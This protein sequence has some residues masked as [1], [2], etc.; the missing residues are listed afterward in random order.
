[1]PPNFP[2]FEKYCKPQ[3]DQIQRKPYQDT[4]HLKTH[5]HKKETLK[6]S[7]VWGPTSRL[8]ADLNRSH[9]RRLCNNHIFYSGGE[10]MDCQSTILNPAKKKN[11]SNKNKE[12]ANGY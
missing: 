9:G 8:T 7:G 2:I 11:S 10:R 3:A 6:S 4:L 1:M 5:K 12:V